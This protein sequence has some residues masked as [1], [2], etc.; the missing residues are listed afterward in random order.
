MK[1]SLTR[2]ERLRKSGDIRDLFKSGKRI[3]SRGLKLLFK[4]NGAEV[5]RMAVVVARGCGGSVKRNRE[6]RI[7]R[8]AYRDMKNDLNAGND[9]VFVISRFG[10]G[11]G[12]RRETL[13]GL[14]RRAL[15]GGNGN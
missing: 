1:K 7:T 8:E 5:N 10:Q 9:L 3:E 11:Y 2:R 4:P 12:E 6:K 15:I 14:L 13:A